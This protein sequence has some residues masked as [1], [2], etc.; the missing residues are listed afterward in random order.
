MEASKTFAPAGAAEIPSPSDFRFG[1]L[2]SFL[3]HRTPE[4]E[5]LGQILC[6]RSRTGQKFNCSTAWLR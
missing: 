5:I 2:G 3:T 6:S 1:T 4:E